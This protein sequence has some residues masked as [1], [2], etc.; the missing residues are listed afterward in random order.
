M[1]TICLAIGTE[2][3]HIYIYDA[4]KLIGQAAGSIVVVACPRP[5]SSCRGPMGEGVESKRGLVRTAV[6]KRRSVQ[7]GFGGFR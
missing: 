2:E 5:R 3:G 1:V 4:R 7:P 6:S